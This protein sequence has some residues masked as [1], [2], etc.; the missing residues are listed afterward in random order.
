MGTGKLRGRLGVPDENLL[1]YCGL[2]AQ[3]PHSASAI[4]AALGDYLGVTARLQQFSG[5]WFT[6]DEESVT[7]LGTANSRLGVNTIAGGRVWDNQ[8]KF[9]VRLGPLTLER[10]NAL[11][12]VGSAFE[13]AADLTRFLAGSEF[14]FDL[15]LILGAAEVPDCALATRDGARPMLGW[16]TWL[17]TRPFTRDDSQVVLNTQTPGAH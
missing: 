7:R 14:D 1:G 15:Q 5:Q 10:F 12:P 11:L 16:N 6:L 17:K 3:R 8:S 13:P 4:E 9:R 2:I